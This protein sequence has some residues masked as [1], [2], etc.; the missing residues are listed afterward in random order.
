MG[1]FTRQV[2]GGARIAG[3]DPRAQLRPNQPL[4][5]HPRQG[6]PTWHPAPQ[7]V[8]SACQRAVK[9]CDERG[10]CALPCPYKVLATVAESAREDARARGA[11]EDVARLA[12]AFAVAEERIATTLVG[13]STRDEVR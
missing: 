2:C 7:E 9:L 1:L 13:K 8:Q 11:G 12:I 10:A 5:L 4:A 3:G 6:P